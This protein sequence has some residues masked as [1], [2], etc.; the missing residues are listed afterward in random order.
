LRARGAAVVVYCK[1]LATPSLCP[2]AFPKG[3]K[4][5]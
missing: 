3:K 5:A 4:M 1:P 2:P